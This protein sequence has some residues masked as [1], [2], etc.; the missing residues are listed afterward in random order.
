MSQDTSL[1][2]LV[3]L[4]TELKKEIKELKEEQKSNKKWLWLTKAIMFMAIGA[5]Y[6]FGGH[7]VGEAVSKLFGII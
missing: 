6:Y 5:A 4:V 2:G 1:R 7:D 3:S